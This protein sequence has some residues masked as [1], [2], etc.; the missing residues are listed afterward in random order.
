[1]ISSRIKVTE[2]LLLLRRISWKYPESINL[3]DNNM[4]LLVTIIGQWRKL[5]IFPLVKIPLKQSNR[6]HFWHQVLFLNTTLV[7]YSDFW[8]SWWKFI[9]KFLWDRMS[10]IPPIGQW[11]YS[12]ISINIVYNYFQF[13]PLVFLNNNRRSIVSRSEGS[14]FPGN[15]K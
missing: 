7:S 14:S 1:M 2:R 3:N 8:N 11:G 5:I 4:D 10:K 9:S 6:S 12:L 15:W 13:S